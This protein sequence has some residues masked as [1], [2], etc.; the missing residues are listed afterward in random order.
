M[1]IIEGMKR[2]RDM[3]KMQEELI[4]TQTLKKE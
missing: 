2:A 1:S 3:K 4:A